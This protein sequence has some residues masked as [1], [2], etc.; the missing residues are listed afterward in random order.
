[1]KK[2]KIALVIL[3][4]PFYLDKG[5]SVRARSNVIALANSGLYIDLL[6]YPVGN[7][8]KINNVN[9]IRCRVPFYK[10]VS[11]GPSLSK[12]YADTLLLFEAFYLILKGKKKYDIIIGEDFEGGFIGYT[13]SK[14]FS[15]NYVYEM[16]NPLYE[17]LRPYTNNNIL[18]KITIILDSFL[19]KR[20]KN[21]TVEWEYEKE[22][23]LKEYSGKNIA[24]VYDAFPIQA[25]KVDMFD[26]KKYIFYAGNFKEYQGI[27]FFLRSFK[28]YLRF[29]ESVY[30]VLAGGNYEEVNQYAQKLNL[31]EHVI[32]TGNL[33]LNETNYLIKNSLFCILPRV[34]DGPPGMKALHYFSQGKSILATN[35]SCNSK[36]IEDYKSGLLVK[37][38]TT[39]MA[40]GIDKMVK[41]EK[42][43]KKLEGYISKEKIGSQEKADEGVFRLI[44]RIN[45]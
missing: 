12:M 18:L 36:L 24:L 7:D 40:N 6:T 4:T 9:H 19:E 13:L 20:A 39:D 33:S 35:L 1:M 42:F 29:G 34:I 21:I 45:L 16:Y 15:K 3:A 37:P 27:P 44:N 31:P 2:N 10:K 22:R 25:K 43:R 14:I 11:A 30:L 8:Y 32:F 38:N 41:D 5:S 28:E 17:T 26:K 23:L